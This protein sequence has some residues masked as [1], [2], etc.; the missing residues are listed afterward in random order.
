MK[1]IGVIQSDLNSK[2]EVWHTC[3]MTWG[4]ADVSGRREKL[5]DLSSR[6]KAAPAS[7]SL[8]SV[9]RPSCTSPLAHSAVQHMITIRGHGD[10]LCKQSG[11]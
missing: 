7:A 11:C 1:L 2:R 5:Q 10:S 4:V 3:A 9:N 8:E 6:Y